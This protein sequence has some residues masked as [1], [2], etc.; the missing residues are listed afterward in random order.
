MLELRRNS[1]N[2]MEP[3]E[4][5]PV[6]PTKQRAQLAITEATSAPTRDH[7]LAEVVATVSKTKAP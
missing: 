3:A 4:E 7:M 2:R 1:K 5:V 6:R